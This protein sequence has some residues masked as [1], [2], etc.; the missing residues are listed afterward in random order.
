[1]LS[2][3]QLSLHS[4]TAC[5]APYP[6]CLYRLG[7][8]GTGV[9][10]FCSHTGKCFD[11][12]SRFL[13]PV[14]TGL[15]PVNFQT[16]QASTDPWRKY[17]TSSFGF[18]STKNWGLERAVGQHLD[19]ISSI[20]RKLTSV[21]VISVAIDSLPWLPTE[22]RRQQHD[23]CCWFPSVKTLCLDISAV[24]SGSAASRSDSGCYACE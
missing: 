19:P 5:T 20:A 14:P 12:L 15:L 2:R 7:P 21:L 18:C 24:L 17:K 4:C 3:K 6:C 23:V 13:K 8:W 16:E 10:A 9:T 11:S 1:M 22:F